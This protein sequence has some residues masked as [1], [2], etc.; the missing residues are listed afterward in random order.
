MNSYA[1]VELGYTAEQ[2]IQEAQRCLACGPCSECQACVQVCKPNAIDLDQQETFVELEIGT[3]I[4]A[5]DSNGQNTHHLIPKGAGIFSISPDD[6]ISGSAAAAKSV[7][8][9]NPSKLRLKFSSKK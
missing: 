5:E 8:A 9:L 6:T 2:A 1:E 3:I 4:F 7:I